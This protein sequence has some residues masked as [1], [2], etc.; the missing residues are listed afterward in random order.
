MSYSVEIRVRTPTACV[1]I[2]SEPAVV[3]WDESNAVV[4]ERLLR[5]AADRVQ[6]AFYI[7][8]DS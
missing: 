5:Q 7:E 1:G 2:T 3:K 6:R 8:G 4:V